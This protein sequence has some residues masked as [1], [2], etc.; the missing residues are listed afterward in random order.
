MATMAPF[1]V[2]LIMEKQQGLWGWLE[3]AFYHL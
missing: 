3:T 2:A 1:L